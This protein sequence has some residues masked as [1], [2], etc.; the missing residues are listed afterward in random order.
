MTATR[1]SYHLVAVKAENAEAS[2]NSEY[3]SIIS[4][5]ESFDS[6]LND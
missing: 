6:I 1:S 2:E 5:V 3:L 4:R